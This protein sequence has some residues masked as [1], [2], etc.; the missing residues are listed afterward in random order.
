MRSGSAKEL[1]ALWR[2]PENKMLVVDSSETSSG[3]KSD[4]VGDVLKDVVQKC[5]TVK[6][7]LLTGDL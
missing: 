2:V 7:V 6:D 5:K 1:S 4:D 3:V